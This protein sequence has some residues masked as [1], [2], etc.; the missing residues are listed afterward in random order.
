MA[1]VPK[2]IE[3]LTAEVEAAR[4][5]LRIAQEK[6]SRKYRLLQTRWNTIRAEELKNDPNAIKIA[7][8]YVT[9]MGE[10]SQGYHFLKAQNE[11]RWKDQ[12]LRF[13]G[14]AWTKAN[15]YVMSISLDWQYDSAYLDR[16]EAA[17]NNILPMIEI[18]AIDSDAEGVRTWKVF[19]ITQSE[20]S[21][22][23]FTGTDWTV[24][25]SRYSRV[26]IQARGT[27]REMLDFIGKRWPA[28]KPY[29]P[30]DDEDDN[31]Y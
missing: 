3:E 8:E 19:K 23:G 9:P 14:G 4:A 2:T 10:N 30:E 5:E 18:G 28:N 7:L 25:V 27:L 13:E 20:S 21:M 12:G 22:L 17:I 24:F 31:E 6:F 11:V 16:T 29:V 15:Q 26:N 1:K